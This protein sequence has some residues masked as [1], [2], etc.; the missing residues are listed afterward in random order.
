MQA[1]KVRASKVGA[2]MTNAKKA[3]ELS[4]TAKTYVEEWLISALYGA[5]KEVRSK[6]LEKGNEMEAS[7]IARYNEFAEKNTAHFEN[8]WVTGTPDIVMRDMI[9]DI[10]CS[11]SPFTFPLFESEVPEKD[12][13]WQL[14]AYMW[15]TGRKSAEL[16]YCL[17]NTPP[18]WDGGEWVIYDSVPDHLRIKVFKIEYDPKIEDAIIG[19][20]LLCRRYADELLASI[21]NNRTF[22]D[23]NV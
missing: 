19:R 18:T 11:Y 21:E 8:E 14:Q 15:L 12:Y 16:V 6:Y 13:Y 9:A 23:A 3:G 20:V 7:A 1:F 5:E 17:E 2:I 4:A 22:G 10:K